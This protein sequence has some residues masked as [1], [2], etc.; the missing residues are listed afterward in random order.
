MRTPRDRQGSF[1]PMLVKTRLAGLD[2]RI[3]GLDEGGM[4]V[5]DFARHLSD[6]YGTEIGRDTISRSPTPCSRTSRR[7]ARGRWPRSIRSSARG[8]IGRW[9]APSRAPAVVSV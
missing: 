8:V 2:D 7:G 1:E 9:P 6:F 5:R 4:T 3:L